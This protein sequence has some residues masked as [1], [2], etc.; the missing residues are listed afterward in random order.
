MSGLDEFGEIARLFRPLTRGAPGAFNLED[1]AAVLP[2]R[3]GFDVVVTTDAIIEGVHF[4]PGESPELVGR[5]LVRVNMSDL[6]A[7]GAE[8]FGALLTVAWPDYYSA[9]DRA[10]FAAG[11]GADLKT[12]GASLLGGDTTSTPGPLT[13]S[14]TAMG[15]VPEGRMVRRAGAQAGDLVLVSGGIGDGWL[16]L[17][18]VRGEIEDPDGYL[19][20]RY[21]LPTP[22]FNLRATLRAQATAAADVSD[23]LVADA[24]HIAEASG[25]AMTLHLD[26]MPLSPAARAWADRQ[27]DRAAALTQ[28]ASGGDDYEIVC[29]APAEAAGLTAI[30]T[31]SE[32]SGVKVIA[33][34]RT[35]DPGVGGWRHR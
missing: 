6:A 2:A 17:K 11:L 25:V 24:R 21:R 19:V 27:N 5:K 12:M 10:A 32:G 18:A 7:K 3:P 13:A 23:G 34:G 26:R 16:G 29:T 31:V 1:D 22:R 33:Q 4:L 28:L 14:L 20:D 8:P 35:L 15:W 9:D 30:G